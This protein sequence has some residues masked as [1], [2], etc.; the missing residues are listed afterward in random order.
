MNRRKWTAR[1]RQ[2]RIYM[3]WSKSWKREVRVKEKMEVVMRMS[4][5]GRS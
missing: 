3:I 5:I 1:K 4:L 2:G